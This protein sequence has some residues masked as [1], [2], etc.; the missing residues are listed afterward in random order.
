MATGPGFDA[1]FRTVT[2]LQKQAPDSE[3]IA[4]AF[5]F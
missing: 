5:G 2:D 4:A 1:A 3:K